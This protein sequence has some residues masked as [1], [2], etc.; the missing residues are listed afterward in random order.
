MRKENQQQKKQIFTHLEKTHPFSLPRLSSPPGLQIPLPNTHKNIDHIPSA[1]LTEYYITGNFILCLNSPYVFQP[2][3]YTFPFTLSW[4]G[5]GVNNIKQS[6]S[7]T[8][9]RKEQPL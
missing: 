3:I 1:F 7:Q 5:K 4:K 6:I 9:L 8:K 2:R